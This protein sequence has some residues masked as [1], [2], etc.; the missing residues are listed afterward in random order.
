M[1]TDRSHLNTGC[2]R[3]GLGAHHAEENAAPR[4]ER[5][6]HYGL[7]YWDERERWLERGRRAQTLEVTRVR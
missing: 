5:E 1:K 2:A 6:E 4:V 3:R 7:D